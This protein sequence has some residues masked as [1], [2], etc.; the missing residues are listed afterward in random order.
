MQQVNTAQSPPQSVIN[1]DIT[2]TRRSYSDDDRG[3]SRNVAH[4]TTQQSQRSLD[5]GGRHRVAKALFAVGDYFSTAAPDRFDDSDF[6]HGKAVDF[7][8]IPGEEQRNRSLR[9]IREQY[10]HGRD[11]D[12]NMT[13]VL[14]RSRSRA[15]SFNGSVA[16]GLGIEGAWAISSTTSPEFSTSAQP[17][18]DDRNSAEP[19]NPPP[20]P[21][22]GSIGLIQ[23][24]DTL[25]VPLP[26]HSSPTRNNSHSIS[27]PTFVNMPASESSPAIVVSSDIDAPSPVHALPPNSPASPPSSNPLPPI[28]PTPIPSP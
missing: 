2:E 25:E 20:Q 3:S 14:N 8:E 18:A 11:S 4:T 5:V 10:N 16:S 13:P 26:I 17:P 22:T 9:Q 6:K 15:T 7:P 19:Q 23:R 28:P 27:I 12:T 24:R 1:L 21:S